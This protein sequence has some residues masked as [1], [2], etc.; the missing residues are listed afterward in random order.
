MLSE[1]EILALIDEIVL[2]YQPEKVY[3]FGS[4][5][6]NAASNDSDID[7]FI[8]KSTKS[9]KIDRSMEVRQVIKTYP[10]V[11]LDIIVYTPD[12]LRMAQKDVVNIGKEAV[13]NG[14]LMYERV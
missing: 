7:L 10:A 12:E 13:T 4:Y 8:I 14:K 9:R 5:A 3:L 1:H 11:G 2:G 6:L